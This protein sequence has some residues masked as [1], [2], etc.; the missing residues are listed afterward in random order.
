MFTHTDLINHYTL[1]VSPSTE[2]S[3]MDLVTGYEPS[4]VTINNYYI[5]KDE[6]NGLIESF[7]IYSSGLVIFF[8]QTSNEINIYSNKEFQLEDDGK[9]HLIK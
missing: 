8:R 5:N 4:E 1:T 3:G 6:K 2:T 9:F 7:S